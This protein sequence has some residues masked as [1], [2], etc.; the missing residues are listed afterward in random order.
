MSYELIRFASHL[1]LL[2]SGCFLFVFIILDK[3][4]S[5]VGFL[6]IFFAASLLFL[7]LAHAPDGRTWAQYMLSRQL[8][9]R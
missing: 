3:K 5:L 1:G 7:S 8:L 4:F 6:M 9:G 2:L